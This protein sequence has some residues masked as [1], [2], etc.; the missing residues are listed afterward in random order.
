MKHLLSFLRRRTG[1]AL[2]F[3]LLGPVVLAPIARACD[4]CNVVFREEL[5]GIRAGSLVAAALR[6]RR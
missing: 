5:A 1:A 6:S 2:L 3:G 4:S